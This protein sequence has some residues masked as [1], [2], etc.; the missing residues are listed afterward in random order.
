MVM[1]MKSIISYDYSDKNKIKVLLEGKIAG[2]INLEKGGWRYFPKGQKLGG[3]LFDTL[4]EC[5]KS[6]E[7][8]E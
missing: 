4:R 2:A 5:Q 8:E 6:L 7:S 1:G 3:D